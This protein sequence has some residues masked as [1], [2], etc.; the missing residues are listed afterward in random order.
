MIFSIGQKLIKVICTGISERG[1]RVLILAGNSLQYWSFPI[2]EQEK[3][4][5]DEDIGHIV[6]QAFQRRLWVIIQKKIILN[7]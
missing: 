6:T 7:L 2:G 3:I 5:F 1:S 4:E